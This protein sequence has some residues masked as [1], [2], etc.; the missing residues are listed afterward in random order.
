[1][2]FP[3]TYN[4]S[5]YKG[6]TYEFNIYPK[7]SNGQPFDMTDYSATFTIAD[8]RGANPSVSIEGYSLIPTDATSVRCA[9]LP[10]DAAGLTAG[11]SYVYDIQ[12]SKEDESLPYPLTYT[13]LTGNITVTSDVTGAV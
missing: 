10:I 3:G 8:A 7:D 9:I 12:I 2:A 6:D 11:N 5:Y 4:I 1:M 13:L